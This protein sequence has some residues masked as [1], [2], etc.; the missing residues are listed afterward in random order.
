MD[1]P[2]WVP[3]MIYELAYGWNFLTVELT[4]R[5][6]MIIGLAS[7]MGRNVV[8]PMVVTYC[9]YHFGK[10]AGEAMS[11]IVGGYILGVIALESRSIFGGVLIHVG[12]AW[13]MEF[14]A[15][16]QRDIY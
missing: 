14:F 12:V 7:V 2:E 15:W 6:F 10:P 9:F 16:L 8:I 3:A 4:F 13:L 11:S 5:G 1:S